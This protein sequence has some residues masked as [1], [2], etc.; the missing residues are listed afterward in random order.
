M[1]QYE[2]MSHKNFIDRIWR[3]TYICENIQLNILC[4]KIK[5]P[6]YIHELRYTIINT[7]QNNI[8]LH[9]SNQIDFTFDFFK[10]QSYS[11]LLNIYLQ[12]KV[13]LAFLGILIFIKYF[14]L[15]H[16]F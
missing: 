10:F 9:Y 3:D 6:I 13:S 5:T 11:E 1:Q 2:I 16:T 4:Q 14:V 12:N 7:Q 15:K 8:K